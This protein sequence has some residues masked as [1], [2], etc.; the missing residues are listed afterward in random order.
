[1]YINC[2]R[3]GPKEHGYEHG[4]GSGSGCGYGR[5]KAKG[6]NVWDTYSK[7]YIWCSMFIE[8]VGWGQN[9]RNIRLPTHKI[10]CNYSR[11]LL[12]RSKK[13]NMIRWMLKITMYILPRDKRIYTFCLYTFVMYLMDN[14]HDGHTI[15]TSLSFKSFKYI[16]G[17]KSIQCI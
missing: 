6:T 11:K 12:L 1:M 15:K 17:D 4:P 10:V 3:H 8:L 2:Q 16:F 9:V 5:V 14:T 7:G 13:I